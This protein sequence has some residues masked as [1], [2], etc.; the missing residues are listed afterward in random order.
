MS[1]S[2]PQNR[3]EMRQYILTKLGAPVIEIN[4]ADEQ[5]D[6]AIDD[7][8]QYFNERS[9]SYGTENLYLTFTAT[10]E[11]VTAFTSFTTKNTSQTGDGVVPIPDRPTVSAEGMVSELTLISPGAGYPPNNIKQN[12][13]QTSETGNIDIVTQENKDIQ[14]ESSLNIVYD[15]ALGSD[16]SGTGL[17]V[18]IG[19]QRTTK[20]GI[21][22][23]TINTQ[24][25]SSVWIGE[26]KVR[27]IRKR[28]EKIFSTTHKTP[29]H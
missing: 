17:T 8:F 19:P 14:T 13:V 12:S 10:A 9:H 6:I 11:F 5:I 20:N 18:L 26:P 27:D 16:S 1:I 15:T 28:Y 7:A 24:S 2:K 4:V 21:T 3:D 22:S 25:L 29:H 23:V